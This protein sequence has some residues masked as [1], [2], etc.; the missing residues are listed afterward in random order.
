MLKFFHYKEKK[1]YLKNTIK[2]LNM[3]YKKK[4]KNDSITFCI[5]IYQIVIKCII[6]CVSYNVN[7]QIC[8]K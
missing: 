4:K 1:F 5:F 2:K 7:I 3:V 6:D 8:T